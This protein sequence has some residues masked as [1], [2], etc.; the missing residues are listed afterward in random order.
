[1][2]KIGAEQDVSGLVHVGA[3]GTRKFFQQRKQN[4]LS[5]NR[6]QYQ[7]ENDEVKVPIEEYKEM[8]DKKQA[9]AKPEDGKE[10]LSLAKKK[11]VAELPKIPSTAPA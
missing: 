10:G 2:A 8:I 7:T 3:K 5:L 4:I 11:G 9:D 1:L 6:D